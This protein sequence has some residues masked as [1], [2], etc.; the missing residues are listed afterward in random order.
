MSHLAVVPV[1]TILLPLRIALAVRCCSWRHLHGCIHEIEAVRDGRGCD[2]T[3]LL[4]VVVERPE[5]PLTIKQTKINKNK[6]N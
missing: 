4:R 2:P 1:V 6:N 5:M 3:V